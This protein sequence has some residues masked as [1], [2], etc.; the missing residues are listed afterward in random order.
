[1]AINTDPLFA[2][3]PISPIINTAAAKASDAAVVDPTA[4][5]G[6]YFLTEITEFGGFADV[7]LYQAIGA[8]APEASVLML[9]ITDTA[10]ANAQV[11][12]KFTTTSADDTES[13]KG[14]FDISMF[15]LAAGV[16]VYVSA[17]S[18]A[19]NVTYNITLFGGQFK[20]Q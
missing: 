8:G 3:S 6:L 19:V 4:E 9:W 16:K 17:Q 5:A 7:L 11:A 18:L 13:V 12:H 14:A 1:M 10:G 15:N 2:G 20:A